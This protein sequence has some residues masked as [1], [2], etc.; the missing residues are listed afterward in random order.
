MAGSTNEDLEAWL[1]KD[2]GTLGGTWIAQ[3]RS[4][5]RFPKR[6][7]TPEPTPSWFMT[8]SASSTPNVYRSLGASTL[9]SRVQWSRTFLKKV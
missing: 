6:F 9:R 3:D 5:T 1:L 4:R 7:S 2:L 8:E